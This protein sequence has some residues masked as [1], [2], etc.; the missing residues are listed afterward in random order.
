[1]KLNTDHRNE[2]W[3]AVPLFKEILAISSGLLGVFVSIAL[4]TWPILDRTLINDL[5]LCDSFFS[6][7]YELT[8]F[9]L[10]SFLIAYLITHYILK[11]IETLHIYQLFTLVLSPFLACLISPFFTAFPPIAAFLCRMQCPEHFY[12][13]RSYSRTVNNSAQIFSIVIAFLLIAQLASSALLECLFYLKYPTIESLAEW[14]NISIIALIVVYIFRMIR[15]NRSGK[16][17]KLMVF[18]ILYHLIEVLFWISFSLLALS[19]W[20]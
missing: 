6:K 11:D 5:V 20:L 3:L 14:I 8:L 12:Y 15:R 1:M 2:Q 13:P 9:R 18:S 17:T 4:C 7:P 10:E 16:I 19:L